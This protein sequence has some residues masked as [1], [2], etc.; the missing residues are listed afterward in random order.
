MEV[1]VIC[2]NLARLTGVVYCGSL[3]PLMASNS[4]NGAHLLSFHPPSLCWWGWQN[5]G[6]GGE[7]VCV[8][9][10]RLECDER[11]DVRRG[12]V[13]L[14]LCTYLV[15]LCFWS[16]DA[17]KVRKHVVCRLYEIR[18]DRTRTEAE[19]SWSAGQLMVCSRLSYYLEKSSKRMYRHI[20]TSMKLLTLK[21]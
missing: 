13:C 17:H 12:F 18:R 6:G 19:H 15:K 5:M 14:R 1:G 4:S 9:L 3:L 21:W 20:S 7:F 2:F 11:T 8:K 16:R 10:W